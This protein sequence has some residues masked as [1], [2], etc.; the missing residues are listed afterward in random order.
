MNLIERIYCMLFKHHYFG[1]VYPRNNNPRFMR[2][3]CRGCGK[4]F[5]TEDIT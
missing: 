3:V 4:S 1:E 2:F 5:C